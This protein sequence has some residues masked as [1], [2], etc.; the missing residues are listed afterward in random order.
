MSLTEEFIWV[1]YQ[2]KKP[3]HAKMALHGIGQYYVNKR[4]SHSLIAVCTK[5]VSA[6]KMSKIKKTS[7][8]GRKYSSYVLSTTD[9][10]ATHFGGYTF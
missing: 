1:S 7:S 9:C 5:I 6:T 8:E 2:A 10:Q 3:D 4:G